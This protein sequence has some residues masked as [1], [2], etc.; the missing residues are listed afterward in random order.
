MV[1]RYCSILYSF[2]KV[3][4]N[5]SLEEL[6]ILCFQNSLYFSLILS[7]IVVVL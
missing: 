2:L 1:V 6:V 3:H 7:T 5:E 4:K